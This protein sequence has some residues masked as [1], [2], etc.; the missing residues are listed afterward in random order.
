MY[1]CTFLLQAFIEVGDEILDAK[2]EGTTLQKQNMHAKPC[3]IETVSLKID[4]REE[5]KNHQ[6]QNIDMKSCATQTI[7]KGKVKFNYCNT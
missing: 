2:E 1:K 7:Y 3:S 4:T 5:N 6:M